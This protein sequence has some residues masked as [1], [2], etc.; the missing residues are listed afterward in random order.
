MSVGE[1]KLQI[2][3]PSSMSV[4]AMNRTPAWPAVRSP[5]PAGRALAVMP[6]PVP[7]G[8][9]MDV[10][11]CPAGGRKRPVAAM[12]HRR[13]AS[14]SPSLGLHPGG[15]LPQRTDNRADA[16]PFAGMA[17][18]APAVPRFRGL[19]AAGEKSVGK[20]EVSRAFHEEHAPDDG[21]DS[22]QPSRAG[23]VFA[24]RFLSYL[25]RCA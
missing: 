24:G 17:Q 8:F 21:K 3:A 7:A 5:M 10:A 18:G 1:Q 16:E 22:E 2:P 20:D 13:P 9:T 14:L 12:A 6:I 19:H 4:P 15:Y 23:F 11:H 25:S